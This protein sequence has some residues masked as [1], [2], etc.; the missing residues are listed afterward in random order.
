MYVCT[1]VRS[2]EMD[3][4]KVVSSINMNCNLKPRVS[5][6]L[7]Q[8]LVARRNSGIMKFPCIFFDSLN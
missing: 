3:E 1:Y 5:Q 2:I 7:C 6:A 4:E 8:R